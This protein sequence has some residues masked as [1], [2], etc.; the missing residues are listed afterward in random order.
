[1]AD[2]YILQGNRDGNSIIV[3]FH[4][5][6]PDVDNKVGVSYRVAIIETLADDAGV[7]ASQV[8]FVTEAEQLRL[9]TAEVVETTWAFHTH[10]GETLVQKRDRID[11][12]YT[13]AVPRVQAEWQHLL[14]Y[15]GYSRNVP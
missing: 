1:M 2:Y 6:I 12:A 11:A 8:P 13:A 14:A 4:V 10:P 3:A 9:N 7:I 5:P 15:Y